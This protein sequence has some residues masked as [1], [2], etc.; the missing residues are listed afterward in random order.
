MKFLLI[1]ILIMF[2][3]I[4]L[5]S[6]IADDIVKLNEDEIK[7]LALEAILENPKIIEEAFFKLQEIRDQEK[8]AQASSAITDRRKLLEEDPNAPV[9]GNIDG[10]V[11]LV[12]FFDYNC[13]FCKR[14]MGVVQ[15]LLEK[16]TNVRL[17]YR[18]FPILGEGSVYAS[19]AALA[20]RKQDKYEE[21]HWALMSLPRADEASTLVVAKKLGLDIEQL[22]RDM[23]A[24][25][26]EQHIA[27]SMELAGQLGING[28]PSFIAGNTLAPGLLQFEQ[29]KQMLD[30]ARETK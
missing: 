13:G 27:L 5:S 24:P 12:E 28:T 3:H 18:E 16:D 7:R 14:A 23:N 20:A 30:A 15:E 2:S 29:L 21:M 6:A 22:K 19:K 25:E 9:L 4:N 1:A 26:V 10:D 17:V 11:T 8:L